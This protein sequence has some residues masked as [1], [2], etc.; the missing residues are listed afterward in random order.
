MH[1]DFTLY[2]RKVPSGKAVVYYYAYNDDGERLGPWST[3]QTTKTAGRN[4]CNALIRRGL[5]VPGIKGMTTFEV[6]AADFWDWEKSEYLKDRRK[7]R[8]LTF[9]YAEKAKKV[10][11][12]VFIPY[13]GK[14]RLD[15]ITREA[16][17][18][19]MD[20]MLAEKYANSSINSYFSTLQT[21]MK[22][23]AKKKYVVRDPFLDVTKLFHEKKGKKIITRN[24]FKA[25][26]VDDWRTVWEGDFLRCMA[27]KLAALTGM[28]CCEV[29]GLRGEYVFDDH[30]YLCGQYDRYGYRETKTKIKHHIPL[31]GELVEDLRKLMRLN[32]DGF[33]FS[34]DG[35]QKP[36]TG[37]H[38]YNGLLSA[39][40]NIGIGEAEIKERGLT[41]HAWRH[42]CNTEMQNGGLTVQQV[43][44]VTG[45]KTERMTK[46]YTHFDPLE[47][48]EVPKVQA[49]LLK[50]KP[51]KPEGA[52]NG[53][54][55]LTIYKPGNG[56]AGNQDRAS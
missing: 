55:A 30:L 4:Y 22:W 48:G 44:A 54:P 25:L 47:F 8:K 18:K 14:T 19:W 11:D 43:Q 29:L 32:G 12:S 26:F 33:L 3:G 16:I 6:Y 13:F 39:L 40:K 41:F 34:L 37:V 42:F 7:H 31:V 51:E 28:R 38:V 49:D 20:Y 2:T 27:N 56:E 9:G 45:H 36:V 1:N 10:V 15:R 46:L 5:L 17:E 21:M 35:G 50:R 53:R 23:A 24:E 52:G